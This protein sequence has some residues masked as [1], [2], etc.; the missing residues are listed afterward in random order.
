[1]RQTAKNPGYIL[2]TCMFS[3]MIGS[4]H[5]ESD[6]LSDLNHSPIAR[7]GADQIINFS[8]CSQNQA[9]LD[10]S[11]SNDPDEPNDK[12]ISYI[13]TK[14]SGP[15]AFTLKSLTGSLSKWS[16]ENMLPGVYF[17]ELK[18]TDTKG[19]SSKDTVMITVTGALKQYDL[20][21]SFNCHYTFSDDYQVCWSYV[22]WGINFGNCVYYDHTLMQ[23]SGNFPELGQFNLALEENS[24]TSVIGTNHNTSIE[25]RKENKAFIL[26]N[27]LVNFK[28]LIQTG[29]GSFNG[30]LTANSGSVR[31]CDSTVLSSLS[32]LN[33]TGN[34]DTLTKTATVNIRGRIYF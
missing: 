11:Q 20:D 22:F 29:G 10:A 1:M 21:A 7:A 25:I 31:P 27:C 12:I 18:V 6:V 33:I 2:L 34:L 8:I 15:S 16:V 17:F 28:R 3:L 13:W 9:V 23:G 14:I 26:G 4:C 5:R 24:D 32:P 19:I 30:T